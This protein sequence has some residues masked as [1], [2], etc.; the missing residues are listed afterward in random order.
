MTTAITIAGIAI[1]ALVVVL[2]EYKDP[3]SMR[4]HIK[5]NREK[6]DRED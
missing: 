1:F 5:R 6:S 3:N 4:N 2:G